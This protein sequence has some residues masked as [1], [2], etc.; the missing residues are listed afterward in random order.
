M[1]DR[2]FE[3][4]NMTVKKAKDEIDLYR[5][6][7]GS[8]SYG[9]CPAREIPESIL[10]SYARCIPGIVI[11]EPEEV[12]LPEGMSYA[13]LIGVNEVRRFGS[14][15]EAL[16]Y[17]VNRWRSLTYDERRDILVNMNMLRETDRVRREGSCFNT[18]LIRTFEENYGPSPWR[19]HVR[20]PSGQV[21][22]D[23]TDIP[24]N[25]RCTDG[26]YGTKEG[27][28][29]NRRCWEIWD[30]MMET[31]FGDRWEGKE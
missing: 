30:D 1:D 2:Y 11:D 16:H 3:E 27:L 18:L 7:Y 8:A 10:D 28:E 22:L 13:V 31:C 15:S 26:D 23:L 21:L 25:V 5:D 17:A 19:F 4:V 6:A 9:L 29:R 14:R 20:D 24:Q 12:P